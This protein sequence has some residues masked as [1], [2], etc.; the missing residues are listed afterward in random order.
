MPRIMSGM[1][2]REMMA[3]MWGAV[4]RSANRVSQRGDRA[5]PPSGRA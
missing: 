4:K 3:N 5:V 1:S 2:I